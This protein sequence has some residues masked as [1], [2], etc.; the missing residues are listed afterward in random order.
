MF[1]LGGFEVENREEMMYEMESLMR[2]V[3][4]QLRN[5]INLVLS[6]VLS[7][8]EFIVLKSLKDNGPLN[9]TVLAKELEVSASHITTVTDSL[10]AKELI[11]RKRSDNDR[12]IT[13]IELSEKGHLVLA[14]FENKKTEFFSKRFQCFT[15]EELY[16][17]IKL[18]GKLDRSK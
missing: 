14:E 1:G 10:I 18:F 16:Q 13:V 8:N 4:R 6:N 2:N 7:R 3:V 15:D 11:T 12:R 9:S 5:E 17:L